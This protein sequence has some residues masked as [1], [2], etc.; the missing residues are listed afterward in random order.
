[1][2][3]TVTLQVDLAK[4]GTPDFASITT[5]SHADLVLD[6]TVLPVVNTWYEFNLTAR[7]FATSSLPYGT[8]ILRCIGNASGAG[9]SIDVDAFMAIVAPDIFSASYEGLVPRATGTPANRV[10]QGDGTWID[11]SSIPVNTDQLVTSY[12]DNDTSTSFT[13]GAGHAESIRRFTSSS[14]ITITLPNSTPSGWAV[15]DSMV[16]IRGGTGTLT[17]SSSGTIRSP[18]GNAITVQNGKAVVTLASSGVWE[19]AGNV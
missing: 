15:G 11:K 17:F 13:V 12:T 2:P 18:G 9:Q 5:G 14:A 1:M 10:L 19:L 6:N 8:V 16:F 4:S 3:N 7:Y